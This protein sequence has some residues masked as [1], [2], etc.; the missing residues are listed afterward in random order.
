MPF[1]RPCLLP[2]IV[3]NGSDQTILS[4]KFDERKDINVARNY[5]LL[6]L[7]LASSVP[8][9]VC[10]FFPSYIYMEQVIAQW[11]ALGL[12]QLIMDQ[13][14]IYIETKDVVETTLALNNY[15]RACDCGRGAVF[16]SVARGK[17]GPLCFIAS[18]SFL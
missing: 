18:N 4:T 13:K 9:G 17:V 15:R 3:T 10:V 5:G 16:L 6:L 12:L 2:L 14:L 7:Q 1:Y 11:D 8:D